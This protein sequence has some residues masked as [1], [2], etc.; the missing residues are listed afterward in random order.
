MTPKSIAETSNSTMAMKHGLM[1]GQATRHHADDAQRQED[2][3]GARGASA[4]KGNSQTT[5]TTVSSCSAMIAAGHKLIPEIGPVAYF[6][7][8]KVRSTRNVLIRRNDP[9]GV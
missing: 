1:Q 4:S 9:A 6:E 3:D 8:S 5:A 7:Y 2:A